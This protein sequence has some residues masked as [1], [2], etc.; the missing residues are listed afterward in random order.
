M[1]VHWSIDSF[2]CTI[3]IEKTTGLSVVA[4]KKQGILGLILLTLCA[5]QH[6]PMD[7]QSGVV[8]AQ[9]VFEQCFRQWQRPSNSQQLLRCAQQGLDVHLDQL[10]EQSLDRLKSVKLSHEQ[11]DWQSILVAK[12]AM[13]QQ[14]YTH[15]AKYLKR[16][17][18][19]AL[20]PSLRAQWLAMEAQLSQINHHWSKALEFILMHARQKKSV[21]S[22]QQLWQLALRSVLAHEKPNQVSSA[23]QAWLQ[24]ANLVN[25]YD[26][27]L[28][29]FDQQVSQWKMQHPHHLA[30]NLL[31]REDLAP[32]HPKAQLCIENTRP[33]APFNQGVSHAFFQRPSN[34]KT[35]VFWV[36]NHQH[37]PPSCTTKVPQNAT[38][39]SP[40]TITPP[41]DQRSWT[42]NDPTQVIQQ[43]QALGRAH[44]I[45]IYEKNRGQPIKS[46]V[47]RL[48]TAHITSIELLAINQQEDH[49][50]GIQQLL[51]LDQAKTRYEAIRKA[52]WT[53]MS[54][55]TTR[56]QDFDSIILMSSYEEANKIIPLL[57]FFYADDTPVLLIPSNHAQPEQKLQ[58]IAY[59]YVLDASSSK[60]DPAFTYGHDAYLFAYYKPLLDA[61][62]HLT[63]EGLG[64]TLKLIE[65][66]PVRHDRWYQI[67]KQG[68]RTIPFTPLR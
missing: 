10:A 25:Q 5:C 6:T 40:W 28:T 31:T 55:A 61:Y 41:Q 38:K 63:L 15:A 37:Y 48:R 46:L 47:Q 2:Q 9:S 20:P 36:K 66:S 19:S 21:P 22:A 14:Q 8:E 33:E 54:I 68:R 51:G 35:S 7:Q 59:T 62:P 24:L 60:H 39:S 56:R 11:I 50:Q 17:K 18:P 4:I 67:S 16:L 42:S 30:L 65:S 49:T 3:K 1:R 64:G 53:P 44:P 29:H 43:L 45:I 27:N 52:S 12:L 34:H 57:R 26:G 23:A 58:D 32:P 13:H